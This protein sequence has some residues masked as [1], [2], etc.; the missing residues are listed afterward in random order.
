M[1]PSARLP[2]SASGFGCP[3]AAAPSRCT[4]CIA[5]SIGAAHTDT[6]GHL[7]VEAEERPDE[8]VPPVKTAELVR[9]YRA[10]VEEIL[11]LRGDDGRISSFLRAI[12][13]PGALADTCAYAPDLSFEERVRL[14]ET[15]TSSSGSS[16]PSSSSASG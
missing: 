11:D 13:E 1:P 12:V 3:A 6:D 8:T 2:R 4:A 14:L 16:S 15:S 7:R 9:E 10:V 5:P